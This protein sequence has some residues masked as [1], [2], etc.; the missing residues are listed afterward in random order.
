M[1]IEYD[2][3]GNPKVIRSDKVDNPDETKKTPN[4]F[5]NIP[6]LQDKLLDRFG[7]TE[8]VWIE[9]KIDGTNVSCEIDENNNYRCYGR[10]YELGEWYSNRGAFEK[11]LEIE[12]VIRTVLPTDLI[13]YFEYL[14]LHHVRYSADKENEL[15]L[16]GVKDKTTGKYYTP[17]AVYQIAAMIGVETP[18]C[19]YHGLFRDW[20]TAESL[21]GASAFGA[22]KGEGVIVKAFDEKDGIKMVKIVTD[23]FREIM[24]YDASRVQAKL[25]TEREKREQAALIVTDARIRK[26]LLNMVDEG[27]IS[28]IE[29][30]SP[31]EKIV[32]IRNIGKRV[33]YDC[34]KEEHDFVV[35]F[36]K[37]FGRFAFIL[38]KKF[39]ENL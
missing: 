17:G 25:N 6:Y 21:V 13:L 33:Y 38:S 18:K 32:A 16:I 10:N 37:D 15:F 26:Q 14:T 39:I 22:V 7:P 1:R 35:N 36:G 20:S 30:M 29:N 9:E 24:K 12:E 5:Y 2:E 11:L 8:E 27:I 28:T 19:L 34:I 23:D 4:K 3:N 31:D